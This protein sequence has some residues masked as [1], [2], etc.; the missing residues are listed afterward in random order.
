MPAVPPDQRSRGRLRLIATGLAVLGLLVSWAITQVTA[1]AAVPTPAGWN[2]IFSDDFNGAAGSGVNG[3]N[4]QYTTGTSYPGGPANFGTHEV[5]TMTAS[6][7][8]VA[9]DGA[10]NLKITPQRDGAGNWTSGRIET[11]RADF[12]P[13]AGGK[14]K[15]EARIQ[16][17]NIT[18]A[19][20]AGYWPAF[21]MLGAPYRG[22]YWNWPSVGELD[23]MEN[24]QGMNNAWAT[25]HCGVAPGG[26]CNEFTGI[27]GQKACAST[28]CQAGFHTY[29]LEWDRSIQPETIR[30][31]LDGVQF[32][33][34]N[35]TNM[36][37]VTWADATNHG[38]FIILNVAMGGDFPA[39]FGGG[40]TAATVPGKPM[41][42]DY[43]AAWQ[44]TGGAT[45][46]PTGSTPPPP[47]SADYTQNVTTLNSTQAKISFH[48]TTPSALVDVHYL[49]NGVNQQNFR[50]ADNGG[51][52]EQ[53]VS[54]LSSGTVLEYWFTYEKNGPL[55][56]TP[57][58][59]YTH[60]TPP[61]PPSTTVAT[62]TFT[63]PAGTYTSAQSVAIST[64]TPGATI[65]YT[66]D[67]STPTTSSPV[68]TG[69][70]TVSASTT[71]K[72]IGTASGMTTS[73][74]ATAAYTITTGSP[75]YTQSVVP[76]N[77]AQAKFTFHP[78]APAALVDVHYRIN[79]AGQ[80][81]FRMANNGGTWEKTASNLST[82]TVLEYWF[83]YEK[84]GPL[85]DT[86][87]YTYTHG[88]TGNGGTVAT[89]VLSPPG[90]TYTGAQTVS[91]STSTPGATIR[92]T[93]DGSTPT[94]SSPVYTGPI[95]VSSSKTIKAIGV[96]A[97][98]ANS[99]IGTATYTINAG[100][101]TVATPTFNPPGGTY[102][103]SA[104]VSMSSATAGATIRYTTNGSTP[105]PTSAQYTGPIT[106]TANTTLKA[107]AVKPGLTDSAVVTAAYTIIPGCT[108]GCGGP[109]T[110]P[111]TFQ[112]NTRG[113]WS[114]SQVYIT[115][116]FVDAGGQWNYLKPNGTGA[117]IDH[118]MT[119]AAGHLTKNG[120]NYPN[121]SFTMAQAP[122]TFSPPY[123][124]GGRIY[125]SVGSPVYIPVSPDNMGWGGPDL[126]NPNDPNRDVY[127]DWYE[128][129]YVYNQVAYGG[130]T[131]AVDQ[132]GFPLTSRLVQTSSGYDRTLGISQTRDQV[133]AGYQAA[134]GAAYTP[135]AGQH[136]IVAP[137]SASQFKPGGAQANYLQS[138]IDQVWNYYTANQWT[139]VHNGVTFTG[140]V[141]NGVLTGTKQDGS[142][143]SVRKPTTTEVF[144]CSGAL[145]L[146]N[147]QGGTDTIREVGRDFCAAFH[148]GVALNTAYW[149]DPTKYYL[150]NPKDDY[151]AYFHAIGIDHKAYA[152]AYDDV[153]DQ[154]SVQILSN[155]NPP[156]SLTLGIGW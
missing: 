121:M 46:T 154:S 125:I 89:P 59:T 11:R 31:Y 120:V 34:V 57:H 12:Q 108:G 126:N 119:D 93:Q 54:N 30:F 24:V 122:T 132:F 107:I 39:A 139:E 4:W 53:T 152:F 134:V 112:N 99:G 110:F 155:P 156:T 109:G 117:H 55:Y 118:A 114:N 20:A 150:T 44:S 128:Y 66:T 102:T 5:E 38:F 17:P 14:L 62:P 111:I 75:D 27:G 1:N 100:T 69:P 78:T 6:T 145:A 36:D 106:L 26:S 115:M 142:P 141:V 98:M 131:T 29:G 42:V 92:Y 32:H 103:G 77:A 136:R 147:D 19:G 33:Q 74:V 68:Y 10:G 61:P 137:R 86:P 148:R 95:T 56:D 21:W 3:T 35:A 43:V 7:A 76:L 16:L 64:S 104:A 25:V 96:A 140:R 149:Y 70:V 153:N 143:F 135:L 80:Q 83:T 52:W 28:S 8:N 45:P 130:N 13:P 37:A 15:V 101:G 82:G 87:H 105:T 113:T 18:G 48:P 9:L 49:V 88:G 41:V 40:P 72:A 144:E 22:N 94:A 124:R 123:V 23:I 81:S 63:P 151:S 129:T 79:G 133:M 146:G 71:L 51:T 84:N 2:L 50:M 60:G 85:Y 138:Y 58:Y 91:I 73:A 65:R 47:P 116:L 127:Y 67:G 97:G 90:G